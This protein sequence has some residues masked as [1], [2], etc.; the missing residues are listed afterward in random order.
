M[1]QDEKRQANWREIMDSMEANKRRPSKFI[2]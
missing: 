1:T 2:P